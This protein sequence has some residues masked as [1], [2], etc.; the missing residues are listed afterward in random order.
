[1]S[2][3]TIERLPLDYRIANMFLS[4]IRYIGKMI[5]PSGLAIGYP[6]PHVNFSNIIPFV[7][8]LIFVA[9]TILSIY[10]LRRKKYIAVGWLW[11]AGTLIPMIGLVQVSIQAMADRYMYLSM[12]GLLIIIAWSVKDI[13]AKRPNLKVVASVS[14]TV[15]LLSA[16]ILTR[17]QVRHWQNSTELFEHALKVTSNSYI[18]EFGYGCEMFKSARLKEAELHLGNAARIDPTNLEARR[19]LGV[20]LM[21]QGKLDEAIDCFNEILKSNN[22]VRVHYYLATALCRKGN[23]DEAIKHLFTV[24]TLDP[25]HPDA[26][27]KMG[28]ALLATGKPNEA[29]EYF[30]EALRETPNQPEIYEYLGQAYKQLGRYGPAVQNWTKVVELK[31]NNAKVLNNLAWLLATVDDVSVR[32]ANK[33]VE[34]AQRVCELTGYKEPSALDTL[35]AAYAAGG[36]FTEARATAEKALEAAKGAKQEELAGKIESRLRLYEAGR[37]YRQK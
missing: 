24:L 36:K 28:I 20:V 32:D 11:Y 35:A 7:C 6:Y 8:L 31:P 26:H 23:F 3:A 37:P 30:N 9:I 2:V 33:A 17:M 14:A 16:L 22:S 1:M 10:T 15:I 4:Y 13:I 29:I 19:N 12:V 34:F 5:W 25:K 18:A 27:N 21:T